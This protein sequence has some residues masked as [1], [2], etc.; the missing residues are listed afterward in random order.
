LEAALAAL[1]AALAALAA[2]LAAAF[3]MDLALAADLPAARLALAER[4]PL[5]AD[6]DLLLLIDSADG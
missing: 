6:A 3:F 4:P 1:A 5:D 2:P